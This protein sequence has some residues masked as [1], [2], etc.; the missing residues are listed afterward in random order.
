VFISVAFNRY[1]ALKHNGK[2][3]YEYARKGIE[4]TVD[5]TREVHVA[6]L[7]L[8][9]F[10]HASLKSVEIGSPASHCHGPAL[11]LN[12]SCSKG[13]YVRTLVHDLGHQLGSAA[14]VVELRRIR[15]G[16]WSEFDSLTEVDWTVPNI[17]KKLVAIPTSARPPT[18]R[19]RY[20]ELPNEVIYR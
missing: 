8:L 20:L 6:R 13:T 10:Q 16:E 11:K 9:D 19:N 7:E 12:M 14:H 1:S 18:N 4:V 5:K 3:L 2:P 17:L 15:Q